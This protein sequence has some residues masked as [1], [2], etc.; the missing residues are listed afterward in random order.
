MPDDLVQN[1][2]RAFAVRIARDVLARARERIQ[3]GVGDGSIDIDRL[4]GEATRLVTEADQPP[5][6]RLINATGV[7][8]HTNL[9][10][11]P[12]SESAL[13]AV[14]DVGRDYSNLELELESG[15]RGSRHE[16]VVELLRHLT[17]AE[18]ALVVNNNAA[19]VLLALAGLAAGGEVIISRGELVEIGGGFRIPDVLR[20]SGAA[21]V[22]VGTTNRTYAHD[23]A[24]ALN[25]A[26]SALMRV[27]SSNFRVIGFTHQPELRDLVTL[28]HAHQLPL[29]EDLGSGSLVDTAAFGV[30]WEPTI[31]H[32][33]QSGVDLVCFSGDKLLG[34]PQAGIMAGRAELIQTLKQHPL[35]RALRPDKLTLAALAATLGEYLKGTAL[36]NVPVLRMAGT[37][38]DSLE[39][40]VRAIID[41]LGEGR[42]YCSV[43]DGQSAI[44][45][46][47]L[48]EETL[49]TRL[50]EIQSPN[51]DAAGLARRLRAGS[52]P[53]IARIE[54]G[55]ILIDLRTVRPG[56][57]AEIVDALRCALGC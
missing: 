36:Q 55:R 44:G 16:H 45:G 9:G 18:S 7:I 53:I 46:G 52:P 8:I 26:T 17:G 34:G 47:S 42:A 6:R 49:P 27:H 29:I 15:T 14:Q 20:Q 37:S 25:S 31:Q 50:L 11:A 38:L 2:R 5:L 41:R 21:L 10:R 12:L 48:P 40:R 32:S 13:C 3:T 51:S 23:Y 54:R 24:A 33:I 56:D 57:D 1:V 4:I 35:T 22:E 28:A 30:A 19:A 43:A 39:R